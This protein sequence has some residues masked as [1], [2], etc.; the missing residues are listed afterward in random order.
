MRPATLANLV[1][2]SCIEPV[3]ATQA[4]D[5]LSAKLGVAGLLDGSGVQLA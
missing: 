2:G 5:Q 1:R 3:S 4:V